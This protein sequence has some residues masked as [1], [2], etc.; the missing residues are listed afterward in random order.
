MKVPFVL[1]FAE[2]AMGLAVRVC[3]DTPV[4]KDEGHL[5]VTLTPAGPKPG[6]G[7]AL[8]DCTHHSYCV[9]AV[10]GDCPNPPNAV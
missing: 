3:K 9:A 1:V 10:T 7:G 6:G 5:A 8:A 2:E 4:E